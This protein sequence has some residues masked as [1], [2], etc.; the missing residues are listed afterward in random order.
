MSFKVGDRV[1]VK[2]G[3]FIPNKNGTIWN[4]RS[5]G[6]TGTI[7]HIYGDGDILL[8]DSSLF[9]PSWIEKVE[10]VPG[11]KFKI[12]DMVICRESHEGDSYWF[13]LDNTFVG[14]VCEVLSIEK[15]FKR[16]IAKIKHPKTG[17]YTRLKTEW[18]EKVEGKESKREKENRKMSKIAKAG[19]KTI[20][21]LKTATK[22]G[23]DQAFSRETVEAVVDQAKSMLGDRWPE[24]FDDPAA[25][26]I[27]TLTF[28]TLANFGLELF[29]DEIPQAQ[30]GLNRTKAAMTDCASDATKQGKKLIKPFLTGVLNK[31]Q[32]PEEGDDD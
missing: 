7:T 5:V 4:L 13:K 20:G 16:I 21:T 1:R 22:Q 28:T 8:D 3:P 11:P 26:P 23:A 27:V 9:D 2:K 18:L 15:Q 29:K 19:S 12:G 10:D 25:R 24:L 14:V 31:L 30:F 32:K 6:C 17:D